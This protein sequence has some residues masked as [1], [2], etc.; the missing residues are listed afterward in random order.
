[1]FMQYLEQLD[2]SVQPHDIVYILGRRRVL[3]GDVV[4]VNYDSSRAVETTQARSSR[5]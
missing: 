3:L 1:M 5:P 2:N 4:E